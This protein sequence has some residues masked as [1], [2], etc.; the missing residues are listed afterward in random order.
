MTSKRRGQLSWWLGAITLPLILLAALLG[1]VTAADT[2]LERIPVALVNNDELVEQVNEDGEEEIILASRPLVTELVSNEDLGLNW[3]IT[4]SEQAE[5]LLAAGEVYAVLEIPKDFSEAVTTLDSDN[6]RQATFTIRTDP[7]HSYLAGVLGDQL[8]SS[9]AMTI[10]D[11]FGKPLTEG[12]FTALVDLGDGFGEAAEA[13]REVADGTAELAEGVT[14]LKDGS[15]DLR[16]GTA[17]LSSGYEEYDDGLEEYLDG[18][19]ELADGIET[20]N[21]E[22]EGLPALTS[23]V[24]T[25]TDGVDGLATLFGVYKAAG[26]LNDATTVGALTGQPSPVGDK[27]VSD[28]VDDLATLSGGSKTLVGSVDTAISG[29]RTGIDGIDDG[30]DLLA[31]N[32]YP[33]QEGSDEIRSGIVDLASGVVE[34]DDGIGELQEGTDELADG[35]EEFAVNLEE[36]ADEIDSEGLATPTDSELDTLISPITFSADDT[37]ETIGFQE[38]LTAVFIPV[39]LW[40]IALLATLRLPQLG[41][42]VLQSTAT[43]RRLF[44]G[45]SKPLL[46]MVAIQALVALGAM[47]TLGGVA[48]SDLGWTVILV[49]ATAMAFSA[50]HFGVWL[51]RPGL[52]APVSITAGIVQVIT[53]GVLIPIEALPGV[54]QSIGALS[55]MA[56]S[57]DGLIAAIA[58]AESGR[59]IQAIAGL[60]TLALGATI[61]GRLALGRARIRAV[62]SALAL[63][64]PV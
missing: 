27:T 58:E 23:G 26:L 5:Q 36:G 2:A 49:S 56:W 11:E 28:L 29:V 6:P 53:L 15:E 38:T 35:M 20:F 60:I 52:V 14:E 9:I 41:R 45:L 31:E 22:T 4:G 10:S 18:L 24:K 13:A 34:F 30:A 3:V 51:W 50:V 19:R 42:R 55:P 8:G 54:Y 46:A 40:F 7:S 25:Y 59:M 17:D 64:N 43:T 32:S 37:P 44:I 39:G 57:A 62:R 33:L 1:V 61:G 21:R 12:L 47:H 16:S 63:T 48:W